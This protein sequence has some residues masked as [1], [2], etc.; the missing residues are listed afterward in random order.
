M[1][2]AFSSIAQYDL[3]FR[4][5]NKGILLATIIHLP[6]LKNHSEILEIE[7][8]EYGYNISNN[9]DLT[10]TTWNRIGN[11]HTLYYMKYNPK[12]TFTTRLLHLADGN[13]EKS[14]DCG[15]KTNC[16]W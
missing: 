10:I 3:E 13:F 15:C 6:Y 9:D 1:Y 12:P 16:F 2:Y 14:I 5:K 7:E 4:H 11:L 8:R